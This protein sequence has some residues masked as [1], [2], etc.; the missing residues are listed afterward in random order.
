MMKMT[1]ILVVA[2]AALI[3]QNRKLMEQL[4]QV[5]E[6][7]EA[8]EIRLDK[9]SRRSRK[10]TFKQ[11]QFDRRLEQQRKRQERIVKEQAKQAE[12]I[13]RLQFQLEQAMSE[14]EAGNN[15]LSQLFA[16]LD[17]AQAN[18]AAAMPGSR[19]DVR[20]TKQILTLENQIHT[21]E[22]RIAKAQ[23]TMSDAQRRMSAA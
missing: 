11:R 1:I 21:A 7:Q 12:L 19:E 9:L 3:W 18:Q 2:I 6:R 5:S 20:F 10:Q 4:A 15:R 22:K 16:L 8:M 23:F 14:I 17:I 13:S